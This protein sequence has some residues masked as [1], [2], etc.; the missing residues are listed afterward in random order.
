[1][2]IDMMNKRFGRL[3]VIG[4]GGRAPDG[5]IKWICQCECGNIKEIVGT[6]L[7]KGVVKSCGCL[8]KETAKITIQN[9]R[10]IN[11]SLVGQHF[12][13]LVV[14]QDSG[15]RTQ[16]R[17]IIY[18]CQCECG[19][20]AFISSA[21]LI[22]GDTMSCGC[23]RQ[24]HGEYVIEQFLIKKELSYQKEY[25]NKFLQT[26]KGGNLRFDFALLSENQIIGLIEFDG[27]QHYVPS[28]N[29]RFTEEYVKNQQIKDEIKNTY[30]LMHNIPL[31]RIRYDENDINKI[32]DNW[33]RRIDKRG[34]K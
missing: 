29:F 23:L 20:K 15:Q 10:K 19:N 3:T 25:T 21:C 27:K 13:K 26:E 32:L 14:L 28:D 31:L 6:S 17:R 16:Q 8:Q 34:Q 33:I 9:N 2:K 24:S 30:A 4:E 7:R 22:S 12:G 5:S 11:D 18:E 1:M